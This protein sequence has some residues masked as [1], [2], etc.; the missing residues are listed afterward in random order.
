[1]QAVH[2]EFASNILSNHTFASCTCLRFAVRGELRRCHA[3]GTT[4]TATPS[5]S[6]T[7]ARSP[8]VTPYRLPPPTHGGKGE[9]SDTWQH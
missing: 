7:T 6:C 3:A 4:A 2:G 1:V 9:S 5:L 8:L